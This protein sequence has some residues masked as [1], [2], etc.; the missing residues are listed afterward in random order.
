[1]TTKKNNFKIIKI[2]LN[3]EKIIKS[4]SYFIG[5]GGKTYGHKYTSEKVKDINNKFKKD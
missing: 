5:P 2:K 1:M 3:P 4:H